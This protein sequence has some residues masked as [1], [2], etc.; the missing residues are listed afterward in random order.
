VVEKPIPDLSID[1]TMADYG[2]FLGIDTKQIPRIANEMAAVLVTGNFNL[3]TSAA[4]LSRILG[5]LAYEAGQH[6]TKPE[7]FMKAVTEQSLNYFGAFKSR[8]ERKR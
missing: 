1:D 4:A 6:G 3:R 8:H 2:Q 5:W 7:D